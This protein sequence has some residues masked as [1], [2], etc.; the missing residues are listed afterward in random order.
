MKT[1]FAFLNTRNLVAFAMTIMG[2][3]TTS[4]IQAQSPDITPEVR[5]ELEAIN[6]RMEDCIA[7]K[8]FSTLIDFYTDDATLM[9]AG[10]KKLQGRKEIAEYWYSLSKATSLKSEIL[11]LGGNGKLVYQVGRWTI[12]TVKDGAEH[13]TTTD[14]VLVWK[15]Q[16]NYDYK[17]QLNSS[18]NPV[19]SNGI[20]IAPF[21]AAKP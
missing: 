3:L 12:T 1:L 6:H 4:A 8:D 11:E 19:A 10:G 14:I 7:K 13:S 16:Q 20:T 2:L 21:E 17:I 9:V 18:N 5:K 15:R